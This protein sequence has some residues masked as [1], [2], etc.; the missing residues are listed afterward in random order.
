MISS[1]LAN[2]PTLFFPLALR[3]SDALQWRRSPT[4][5]QRRWKLAN[6]GA[7]IRDDLAAMK[8]SSWLAG[9]SHKAKTLFSEF[10]REGWRCLLFVDASA[11]GRFVVI[12]PKRAVVA[13]DNDALRCFKGL[14]P[15]TQHP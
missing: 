11:V 3:D 2:T 4:I 8:P 13:A 1:N 9:D 5:S 6:C 12:N 15:R 14:L 10:K 7:E